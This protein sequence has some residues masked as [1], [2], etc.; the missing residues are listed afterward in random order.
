MIKQD[1]IHVS[2]TDY[3]GQNNLCQLFSLL[4]LTLFNI[5]LYLYDGVF[6]ELLSVLLQRMRTD[7]IF[8]RLECFILVNLS[9]YLDMVGGISNKNTL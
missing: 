7:K 2:I 1:F 3:K 5:A 9:M 4:F 8:R 6:N